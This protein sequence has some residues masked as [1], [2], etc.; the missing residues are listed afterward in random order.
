MTDRKQTDT[1]SEKINAVLAIPDEKS[2]SDDI[3]FVSQK[4]STELALAQR[5]LEQERALSLNP[6]LDVEAAL[7]AIKHAELQV[8]RLQNSLRLLEQKHAKVLS[9]EYRTRFLT[10]QHEARIVRDA[11]SER[12]RRVESLFEEIVNIYNEATRADVLVDEANSG[13]PAGENSRLLKTEEH[14]RNLDGFT[15]AR[16]SLMKETVLFGL[17][18]SQLWPPRTSV[19]A[20]YAAMMAPADHRH[21]P[22]DASSEWWM[23]GQR[24]DE[25]RARREQ[26]QLAQRDDFYNAGWG[27]K[28]STAAR[29]AGISGQAGQ[30][31]RTVI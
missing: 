28:R 27:S 2:S 19:G 13:S 18:G 25:A 29:A 22:G 26:E 31:K 9:V 30:G 10:R 4:V 8:A 14:A 15:R 21:Y 6:S 16:P 12:F 1:L 7:D 3:E 17:D 11:A 23:R 24:V 5:K 20:A